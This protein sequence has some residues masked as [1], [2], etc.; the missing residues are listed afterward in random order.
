MS[1]GKTS[2]RRLLLNGGLGSLVTLSATN[3]MANAVKE[4]KTDMEN[5]KSQMEIVFIHRSKKGRLPNDVETAQNKPAKPQPTTGIGAPTYH[6]DLDD[7][8]FTL[9]FSIRREGKVFEGQV[10]LPLIPGSY[11]M[12]QYDDSEK[13]VRCLN[14][15]TTD[16]AGSLIESV[17]SFFFGRVLMTATTVYASLNGR[18]AD[19]AGVRNEERQNNESSEQALM[20]VSPEARFIIDRISERN[21]MLK[22]IDVL[23]YVL[24]L[25]A[26]VDMLT[27]VVLDS[28]IV[29]ASPC[30]D[31]LKFADEFAVYRTDKEA[32]IK[33]LFSHKL[34]MRQAQQQWR[35]LAQKPAEK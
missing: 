24:Y 7:Q 35:A 5:T 8:N 6:F 33:N 26:Q 18:H 15:R 16:Y 32:A 12:L 13:A 14:L 27:K 31:L 1:E 9:S 34:Q 19:V 28:G 2:R 23:D 4:P 29:K 25:E 30:A 10:R 20:R 17:D 22:Q 11:V 3:V 21:A